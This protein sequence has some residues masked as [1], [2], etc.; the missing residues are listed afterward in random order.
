[1]TNIPGSV[2][3]VTGSPAT[4]AAGQAFTVS[5]YAT[6]AYWNQVPSG[7]LVRITSSDPLANTPLNGAL[8][9]GYR[10]FSVSLGTVGTQTLTVTDQ[11]N[12]SIQG[13]TSAGIPVIPSGAARFVIETLPSPVTAGSQIAVTVHAADQLGNTI[14][15]YSG[16]AIMTANTGPGSIY[17]EAISFTNGTWTGN[18]LFKGAGGSVTI[19]CADFSSPPHT[20]TSNAIQVLPGPLAGLQ[21]ILPGQTA[22]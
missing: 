19:T 5:V 22:Q 12:G 2:G 9:N 17:P 3:G 15:T 16:Q 14:P 20:G 6:D 18:V 10:S 21:V 11:T 7:D 4:Q 1:E 8:S 13:M